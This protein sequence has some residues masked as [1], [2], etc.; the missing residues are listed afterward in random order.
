VPLPRSPKT[1]TAKAIAALEEFLEVSKAFRAVVARNE[2]AAAKLIGQ[3]KRPGSVIDAFTAI[4]GA[5]DRPREMAEAADEFEAARRAARQAILAL[6]K[7][8]GVSFSEVARQLGVSR[9]LVSRMAAD[10][11]ES[12]TP[13]RRT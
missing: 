13:R 10:V 7:A 12:R 2:R 8:E 1:A 6:A 3:L 11:R 9:Q 5:M 4:E